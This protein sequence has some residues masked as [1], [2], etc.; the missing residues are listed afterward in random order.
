MIDLNLCYYMQ[1]NQW[2]AAFYPVTDSIV[3]FPLEW[4]TELPNF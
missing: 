3:R 1:K 2:I 4:S